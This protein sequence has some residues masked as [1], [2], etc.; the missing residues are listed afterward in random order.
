MNTS[1]V[2]PPVKQSVGPRDL[3]RPSHEARQL[4]ALGRAHYWPVRVLGRAPMIEQPVRLGDWLLIPA[5]QD[6]TRVPWRALN[7]IQAIFGA[8]IRPQGFVVV[9]EVPKLLKAP[10]ATRR[11]PKAPAESTSSSQGTAD[12]AAAL[13]TGISAL[14]SALLPMLFFV[15]AAAV[16][17]P[18]L[19]AVTD[20]HVWV[21]IDRWNTE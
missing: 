11:E 8:G 15:V 3:P 14:A 12:F 6:S 16:A 5:Q 17:D 1:I 20:D 2:R 10:T 4:V 18:I 13:A 9:H 7:R 19:V 21:E